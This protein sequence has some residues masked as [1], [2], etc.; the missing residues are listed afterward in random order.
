MCCYNLDSDCT[1][2]MVTLVLYWTGSLFSAPYQ[3][4][5]CSHLSLGDECHLNT[6]YWVFTCPHGIPLTFPGHWTTWGKRHG[7]SYSYLKTCPTSIFHSPVALNN[8]A[9]SGSQ[10]YF[11][12]SGVF[13][14]HPTCITIITELFFFVLYFIQLLHFTSG[15]NWPDT[16]QHEWVSVAPDYQPA[17]WVWALPPTHTQFRKNEWGLLQM[18]MPFR[19]LS[20]PCNGASWLL[21]PRLSTGICPGGCR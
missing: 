3:F 8:W 13:R 7:C 20:L 16:E 12:H 11:T 21:L 1:S 17:W 5:I 10:K 9:A 6:G 19:S 18:V 4:F 14:A 15:H 2:L